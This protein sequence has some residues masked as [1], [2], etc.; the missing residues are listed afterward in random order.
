MIDRTV[1]VRPPQEY[2]NISFYGGVAFAL[3]AVVSFTN[4][5][6]GRNRKRHSLAILTFE[7]LLFNHYFFPRQVFIGLFNKTV[8]LEKSTSL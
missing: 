2:P 7:T 8:I 5:I 6:I 3:A 4:G 1:A